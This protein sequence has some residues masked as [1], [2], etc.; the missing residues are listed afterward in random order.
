MARAGASRGPGWFVRV[1]PAIVGL[2]ALAAARER[3]E[4]VAA[5]LRAVR[6][7]RGGLGDALDV[8]RTFVEYAT[9]VADVLRGPRSG[10]SPQ[11]LVR[12]EEH[13]D[14]ALAGGKGVVVVTAHTAGWEMAGG[15]LRVDHPVRVVIVD[16]AERDPGA[17]AIQDRAR[18]EQGVEIEHAG[19]DAFASLRLLGHLRDGAVVALQVD[20][21]GAGMRAR[22][23][24]LFGRTSAIPEGPLRLASASGAPVLPVF[25]G[26]VGHRRY[27]IVVEAP[28][29]VPRR[30]TEEELDAAAERIAAAMEKAIRTRPTQW[31]H[32]G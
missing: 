3:R 18:R 17:R 8:A 11:A 7:S 20:R 30:P 10:E 13:L 27:E 5:S 29:R 4:A 1:A 23:V 31:F 22:P 6:P 32:F 14:D 26:R 9:S 28:I 16:E 12:G 24:R 25:A 2:V 21:L 15:L 19:G